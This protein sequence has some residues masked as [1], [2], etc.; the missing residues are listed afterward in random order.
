MRDSASRSRCASRNGLDKPSQT[1][2]RQSRSAERSASAASAQ[3]ARCPRS[4]RPAEFALVY[5]QIQGTSRQGQQIAGIG[6]GQHAGWHVA[7]PIGLE[8]PAQPGN[9][10]LHQIH[11][12]PG[13]RLTPHG[14]DHLLSARPA[15]PPAAPAPPRP[16]AAGAAQDLQRSRPARPEAGPVRRLSAQGRPNRSYPLPTR[17]ED[18]T[19]VTPERMAETTALHRET[20]PLEV[21]RRCSDRCSDRCSAG[22][23]PE[24]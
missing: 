18:L 23:H 19:K 5:I 11:G 8:H 16:P 13:R 24:A 6:P 15:G 3:V 2:P 20:Q 21:Q 17:M 22:C 9:V 14:I 1:G 7:R 10:P 4:P 12:I